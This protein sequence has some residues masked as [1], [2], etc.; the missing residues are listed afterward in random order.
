RNEVLLNQF[1]APGQARTVE[2]YAKILDEPVTAEQ[3]APD[4]S[5]RLPVMPERM[6]LQTG[7]WRDP[8]FGEVAVCVR[9]DKVRFSAAK[10]P[11]LEGTI[12]QADESYLVAW[13][14]ASV[15]GE[16]PPDFGSP[17]DGPGP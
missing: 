7:I 16:A 9:G 14:D 2:W 15:D 10:S 8:W 6:R 11:R 4:T 3:S 13:D 12:I 5:S 17:C 1:T